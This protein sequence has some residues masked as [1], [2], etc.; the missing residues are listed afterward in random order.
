MKKECSI[1]FY[2]GWLDVA[3][4]IINLVKVLEKKGYNNTV[5][6]RQNKFS[7]NTNQHKLNL[8]ASVAY[9][10]RPENI[11][12]FRIFLKLLRLFKLG[13]FIPLIDCIFFWIQIRKYKYQNKINST[14]D[15]LIIGIDTNG[16][17]VALFESVFLRTNNLIYL[18]LELN[19]S[20]SFRY[21]DKIRYFLDK[22][23]YKKSRCLI[24]QDEDRFKTITEY[25]NYQQKNV[26]YVP[27]S[28]SLDLDSEVLQPYKHNYFRENLQL[29][30]QKYPVIILHAGMICDAVL[31]KEIAESFNLISQPCALIFHERQKRS[32]NES[33]LQNLL[34]INKKNLFLSLS[35]LPYQEIYKVFESIDIGIACY[36]NI[37][38]NFSKISKASG[39]LAFYLKYGKPVLMNDLESFR[40]L[41]DAYQIGVIIQDISNHNEVE[42]ALKKIIDNYDFFSKNSL[43][44]FQKE[45]DFYTN[46]TPF[47]QFLDETS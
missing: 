20:N 37:D 6:C 3:P 23:A 26:F 39:K 32:L 17:I 33:Y 15:E 25:N 27:N 10:I 40:K 34:S 11:I 28:D 31:S 46:I 22:K 30:T 29:N 7:V 38:D 8:P 18:S 2:E 1:V 41:N 16:S 19:H 14:S 43:T 24:I 12:F 9:F 35:P 13:T 5:Y 45:F 21:F 4:T 44:C 42:L 47:L 36:K